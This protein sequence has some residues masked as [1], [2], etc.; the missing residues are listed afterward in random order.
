M[1]RNLVQFGKEAIHSEFSLFVLEMPKKKKNRQT[2]YCYDINK[3]AKK[4]QKTEKLDLNQNRKWM[5]DR[6]RRAPGL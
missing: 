5:G 6:V 4:C 3:S 2:S 1:Y